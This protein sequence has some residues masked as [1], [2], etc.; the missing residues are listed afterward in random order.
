[1]LVLM[2][3]AGPAVVSSYPIRYR[4][5]CSESAPSLPHFLAKGMLGPYG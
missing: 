3:S 2:P 1:M 4:S 5:L